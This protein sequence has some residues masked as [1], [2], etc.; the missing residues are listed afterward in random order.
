M[1]VKHK[2]SVSRVAGVVLLLPLACA[3]GPSSA[4]AQD[5]Q[6]PTPAAPQRTIAC[7]GDSIS[8]SAFSA[9]GLDVA[10][11][12]GA[13]WSVELFTR[14]G[15]TVLQE[16]HCGFVF[17]PEFG[18]ACGSK[19]DVVIVLLGTNDAG[20]PT[21]WAQHQRFKGE[22]AD[23]LNRVS[24]ALPSARIVLC[25]PPPVFHD[26]KYRARNLREASGYIREIARERSLPLVELNDD[27]RFVGDMFPDGI[28]PGP[29]AAQ[30]MA[31]VV[32]DTLQR[33]GVISGAPLPET[34]VGRGQ[35]E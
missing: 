19:A 33:E 26:Q 1:T 7:L 30:L 28:H 18:R 8:A 9:Y 12:L 29:A 6:Q 35:D 32:Y 3:L 27:E 17:T 13:A 24:L 15:Q 34:P 21:L 11:K 22:Y 4:A 23:L 16:P 31:A 5:A 2:R 10:R 25:T 14:G 20:E